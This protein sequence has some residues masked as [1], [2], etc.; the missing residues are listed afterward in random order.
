MEINAFLSSWFY[1]LKCKLIVWQEYL[2]L[3]RREVVICKISG[4]S[5][6]CCNNTLN[7]FH[8]FYQFRTETWVFLFWTV[9][10]ELPQNSCKVGPAV[11]GN[12]Y[13]LGNKT[14]LPNDVE[15]YLSGTTVEVKCHK[16]FE[17]DAGR[18]IQAVCEN[19]TFSPSSFTCIKKKGKW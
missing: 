14:L 15:V 18:P 4:E 7:H 2:K 16:N 11:A 6:Q 8:I 12:G 10:Q 5:L 19:G 3:R 13:V 17:I 9:S 1:F